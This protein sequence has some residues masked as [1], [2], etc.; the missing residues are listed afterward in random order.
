LTS[1][2]VTFLTRV[3]LIL[4]GREPEFERYVAENDPLFSDYLEFSLQQLFEAIAADRKSIIK[5]ISGL[6]E[7]DLGS[8]AYHPKFGKMTVVQWAEFF[9]LHEAHHIYSIFTQTRE[10][11]RSN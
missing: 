8:V 2:Q 10:L 9:L 1:Y 6:S 3:E 4:T 5:K 7:A 11:R